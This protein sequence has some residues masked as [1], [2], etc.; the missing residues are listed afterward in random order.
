MSSLGAAIQLA[1]EAK[2]I[3]DTVDGVGG[4]SA[5]TDPRLIPNLLAGGDLC[6]VVNPPTREFTTWHE[7]EW[8]WDVWIVAGPANDLEAAWA[9][10]DAAVDALATPLEV[11]TARPDAFADQQRAQYP[12]FVLTITSNY[13]HR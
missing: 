9:R 3:L 12:A 7:Q 6:V 8:T 2:G 13:H 11:A 5:T 10:L 1:A 4:V